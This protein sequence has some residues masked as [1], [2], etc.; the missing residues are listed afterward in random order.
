MDPAIQTHK[1][2]SNSVHWNKTLRRIPPP[3]PDGAGP[4]GQGRGTFCPSPTLVFYIPPCQKTFQEFFS[5]I[6]LDHGHLAW[7]HKIWNIK[8][9]F[10]IPPWRKTFPTLRNVKYQRGTKCSGTNRGLFHSQNCNFPEE[11]IILISLCYSVCTEI[12]TGFCFS[13][14]P[15]RKHP[16]I[17]VPHKKLSLIIFTIPAVPAVVSCIYY[18]RGPLREDY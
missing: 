7:K 18:M 8:P 4:N 3:W 11:S 14:I 6:S 15:G 5:P 2:F 16:L 1:F 12:S 9:S 17:K 10:D 13:G